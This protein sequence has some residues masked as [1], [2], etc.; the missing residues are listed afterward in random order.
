M[1]RAG[2][3]V[4]AVLI[5]SLTLFPSANV[6]LARPTDLPD[7]PLEEQGNLVPAAS[8]PG[9]SDPTSVAT[10]ATGW[11]QEAHDAQHIGSTAE[12]LPLPWTFAWQ[13]NGSCA[14]GSDCR[15]GNPELGWSFDVPPDAH[16]VGGG[17]RLYL[18]AGEHGVW[19]IRESDGSTAWHNSAIQSLCTAAFDPETNSLF[20][21]ASDGRL[22]KLNSSSGTVIDSFQ[23]DS[24]LN[25]APTIAGG[26]VFAVSDA[27][28][29]Y[30]IDK[31]TLHLDWSYAAG[32]PGETPAAYSP[33]YDMLVFG[34]YDLNLHA[35]SNTDG[36]L[37]WRRNPTPDQREPGWDSRY[38]EPFFYFTHRW[39]VIAEQHGIVL[40]RLRVPRLAC[41][42]PPEGLDH[43]PATNQEIRALLGRN[44]HCQTLFALDLESGEPAFNA[45]LPVGP[46][47]IE[48]ARP[49]PTE[50]VELTIGPAPVVMNYAN[51][52]EVVYTT[53]RS[54][55][56]LQSGW[57]WGQEGGICEM[58]LDDTTA[59]NFR[60]GDCRYVE[61]A[62]MQRY[63][64]TVDE[65][66]NL[67]MSGDSAPV[68]HYTSWIAHV[69]WQVTDRADWRGGDWDTRIMAERLPT[70]L[71]RIESGHGCDKNTAT[72]YCRYGLDAFCEAKYYPNDGW[73]VFWN[74]TDAPWECS[75]AYSD[76]YRPRY[77]IVHNGSIYYELNGGTIFALRSANAASAQIDLQVQPTVCSEGDVLVA[78]L[79]VLGDGEP[80][81]L[82]DSLPVGLSEPGPIES[83][84]GTAAYD[85]QRR[86]V[87]WNATLDLGQPA[88]IQFP[89]T[90][91]TGGPLALVNTAV[92]TDAEGHMITDS[93][94]VIVDARQVHLPIVYRS[95]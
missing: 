78:T 61:F 10:I 9:G 37:L 80:L 25:R 49:S 12:E 39:P 85:P 83:S 68:L 69:P 13:W 5:T 60:G 45:P 32:S 1:V 91:T 54:I 2:V 43:Y 38:N 77:T 18:P 46:G 92:V 50:M 93:A 53:W 66:G 57:H 81:D 35:V 75:G 84:I 82:T 79:S 40:V 59:P 55:E 51:G 48:I 6:L 62:T 14:D 74:C 95:H 30:A 31:H 67:T 22:Y 17:G 3:I 76:G 88:T 20:V 63:P 86:V 73:W 29:L 41:F 24:G 64:I 33:R 87:T 70:T 16:L 52:D 4:L 11:Y 8:A 19:A 44:P 27:G 7:F 90:V 89:I 58:V 71:N 21:A 72:H 23:A 34:T 36:S 42:V 94:V 56:N 15:P 28:V 65:M 26:R 47:G